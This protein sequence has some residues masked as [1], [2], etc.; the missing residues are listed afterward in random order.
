MVHKI[1]EPENPVEHEHQQPQKHHSTA[2]LF[3]SSMAAPK[4]RVPTSKYGQE[5]MPF[6]LVSHSAISLLTIFWIL[7]SA[8]P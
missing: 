4:P 2:D 7:F 8:S 1:L 6:T 3:D 5:I